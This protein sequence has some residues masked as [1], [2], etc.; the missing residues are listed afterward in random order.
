LTAGWILATTVP[1]R[2]TTEENSRVRVG[3]DRELM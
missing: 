3:F 2:S 1:I